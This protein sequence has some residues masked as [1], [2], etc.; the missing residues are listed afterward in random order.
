[1]ATDPPKQTTAVVYTHPECGYCSLL[2]EDLAA[3]GVGYEE[4][5][6]SRDPSK[7]SEVE[8]LTGGDRITPVTAHPD[9]TVEVGYKGIGCNFS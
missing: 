2:K 6:V 8:E 5:D 9:G 4:V 3:Q 7:W 1:M